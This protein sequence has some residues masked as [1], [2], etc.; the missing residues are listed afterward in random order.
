MIF[1]PLIKNKIPLRYLHIMKN[2]GLKINRKFGT[3]A[4]T[5]NDNFTNLSSF[6]S[7]NSNLDLEKSI[8]KKLPFVCTFDDFT[9]N[10]VDFLLNTE[11]GKKLYTLLDE[12][13]FHSIYLN[14][15]KL[16]TLDLNKSKCLEPF[17]DYLFVSGSEDLGKELEKISA[18]AYLY[19]NDSKEPFFSFVKS[20]FGKEYLKRDSLPSD[21]ALNIYNHTNKIKELSFFYF[22]IGEYFNSQK[23]W[24][25]DSVNWDILLVGQARKDL[26]NHNLGNF[27]IYR[28]Q[29]LCYSAYL[30]D[31]IQYKLENPD[32]LKASHFPR[33]IEWVK[34]LT[35]NLA[36][37][38]DTL[39][40]D[41]REDS[42]FKEKL[43]KN[44]DRSS[45]LNI[46]KI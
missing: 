16:V 37:F 46:I 40:K 19:N 6:N 30:L 31:H 11:K 36:K 41:P 3:L 13:E 9:L 22:A 17:M 20:P 25:Y 34:K 26:A 43:N 21:F 32:Y 45:P 38:A 24:C 28:E 14:D 29:A 35:E 42:V 10:E 23:L 15:H 2:H 1:I 12:P 27:I 4:N 8:A 44:D 5:S 39:P 33:Q 18:G 7:L